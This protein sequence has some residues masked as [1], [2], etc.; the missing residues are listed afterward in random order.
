MPLDCDEKKIYMYVKSKFLTS[1]WP[2]YYSTYPEGKFVLQYNNFPPSFLARASS[3]ILRL[4]PD[5][6]LAIVRY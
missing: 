6:S 4:C 3:F 1:Y 5:P 2:G